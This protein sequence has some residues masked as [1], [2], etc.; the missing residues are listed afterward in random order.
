MEMPAAAD[1]LFAAHGPAVAVHQLT[2]ATP[3][4]YLTIGG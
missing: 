2:G 1:E 3:S 4:G